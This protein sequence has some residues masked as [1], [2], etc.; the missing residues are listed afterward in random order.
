LRVVLYIL[1]RNN[2]PHRNN[3][4]RMPS[5]GSVFDDILRALVSALSASSGALYREEVPDVFTC[6]AGI[7]LGKRLSG[8]T[9]RI[10]RSV[11]EKLFLVG[12][13]PVVEPHSLPLYIQYGEFTLSPP[14]RPL[15]LLMPLVSHGRI[16]GVVEIHNPKLPGESGRIKFLKAVHTLA[17]NIFETQLRWESQQ[18][19]MPE[20]Q[21]FVPGK[22]ELIGTS[23]V[24]LD[25]RALILR[26]APADSTILLKGE[27]GTGKNIIALAIH[28]HSGR[29][30]MPFVKVN[31]AAIPE[32]LL[33]SEL[34]GHEKGAFTGA[35]QRRIGRFERA[36]L[37]TIFLDE[38][39]EIPHSLQ[40]KLLNVLQEQEFERV[41][42]SQTIRVNTRIIAATN[43]DL[44]SAVANGAFREDLYYRLNV[45]PIIVPPLREH[46]EDIEPLANY[47]IKKLNQRLNLRFE[48][49]SVETLFLLK[50]YNWRGNVRELENVIER[51][52]VIGHPPVITPQDLPQ[53]IF[54]L[55]EGVRMPASE[56]KLRE[57]KKSLWDVE[58]GIIERALQELNGNQ[59]KAAHSL[60]I[61]RNQLRYR[62]KKYQIKLVK[63]HK[64]KN[65]RIKE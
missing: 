19:I 21:E 46:S 63:P 62:I 3:G 34:F 17:Q 33:E 26:V 24:I 30:D 23:Q 25:L 48:K 65:Q 56:F 36:H 29:R 12:V 7:R 31:C 37:G 14:Q 15:C 2:Q 27:T 55:V 50:Q 5:R 59:S 52:M 35:I 4:E 20:E 47:F 45:V 44:E 54:G 57:E 41:G 42:S 16:T 43:K 51:S 38:V 53:E 22:T 60:G 13:K 64:S 49:I 1:G 39:G 18:E 8:E 11:I 58:K 28:E 32:N 61:T 10:P 40:V 6:I 9:V